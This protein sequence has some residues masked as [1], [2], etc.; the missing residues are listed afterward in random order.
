MK[1]CLITEASS[2]SF[3]QHPHFVLYDVRKHQWQKWDSIVQVYQTSSSSQAVQWIHTAICVVGSN[4]REE[5]EW[6]LFV[7]ASEIIMHK[8][9][10]MEIT[11]QVHS[12]GSYNYVPLKIHSTK[13]YNCVHRHRNQEGGGRGKQGHVPPKVFS[14]CHI[15]SILC[16][17]LQINFVKNCAPTPP[18]SRSLSY[19][20]G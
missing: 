6:L 15:H 5:R 14:V 16:P 18:Q 4:L 13:Y 2:N 17:V 1:M 19:T 11:W 20:S 7:Q 3:C 10:E 9:K 12:K 8:H